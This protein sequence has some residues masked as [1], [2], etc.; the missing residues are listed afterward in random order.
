LYC[1]GPFFFK[2]LKID[3]VTSLGANLFFFYGS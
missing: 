3:L 1:S 2:N